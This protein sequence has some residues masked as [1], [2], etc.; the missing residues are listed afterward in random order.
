MSLFATII[1]IQIFPTLQIQF[2]SHRLSHDMFK[3]SN[4]IVE[5]LAT[6]TRGLMTE[7]VKFSNRDRRDENIQFRN[8][9]PDGY[10]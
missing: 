6:E 1:A 3:I 10:M 2:T 7:S 8:L 4:G 5:G 9:S